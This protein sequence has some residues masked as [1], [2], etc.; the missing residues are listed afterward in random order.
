MFFIQTLNIISFYFHLWCKVIY[1]HNQIWWI[2]CDFLKLCG[3]GT[4]KH[5]YI[6]PKVI[7]KHINN[8][9]FMICNCCNIDYFATTKYSSQNIISSSSFDMVSSPF[10]LFILINVY[11]MLKFVFSFMTLGLRSQNP[12]NLNS[13]IIFFLVNI[14]SNVLSTHPTKIIL[15]CS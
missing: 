9:W 14:W 6:K 8:S 11:K 13:N 15:S 5:I 3:Y 7:L 12:I 4:F 10:S 2:F 1:V